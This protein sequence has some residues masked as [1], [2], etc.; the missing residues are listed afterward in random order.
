MK[1]LLISCQGDRQLDR[2]IMS[3]S[4]TLY[5]NKSLRSCNRWPKA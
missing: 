5:E 2:A 1:N 3:T 4:V